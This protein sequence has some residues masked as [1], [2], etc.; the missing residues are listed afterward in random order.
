MQQYHKTHTFVTGFGY[1][2]LFGPSLLIIGMYFDKRRSLAN[3]ITVA[4]S[5]V[6][7]LVIPLI[8]TFLINEYTLQ[9]ALI[10]YAAFHLNGLVAGMLMR[11]PQFYDR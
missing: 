10:I 11:P 8:M 4:G 7:Q 1:A 6:G 9:G 2:G 5:S 3:G